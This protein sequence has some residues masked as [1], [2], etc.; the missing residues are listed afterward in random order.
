MKELRLQDKIGK[1]IFHENMKEVFEPV[2]KSFRDV[3]E[4]VEKT[5]METSI[6]NNKAKEKSTNKLL[7]IMIERGIFS[8][9]LMSPLTKITDLENTSQFKLLKDYSSN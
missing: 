4:E 2:T 7:K 5:L 3:S 1:Q 9:Y 6:K 8:S